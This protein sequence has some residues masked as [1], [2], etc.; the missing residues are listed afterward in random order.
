MEIS[1]NKSM[2]SILENRPR[3]NSRLSPIRIIKLKIAQ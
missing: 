2:K 3:G 1:F